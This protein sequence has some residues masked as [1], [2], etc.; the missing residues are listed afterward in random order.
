MIDMTKKQG[1]W[2]TRF[3]KLGDKVF[4]ENDPFNQPTDKNSWARDNY[5]Q[6]EMPPTRSPLTGKYYTS[7]AALRAEYRSHGAEEV[8]TAYENGYDPAE[9]QQRREAD[10]V[11]SIKDQII[12]RYRNGR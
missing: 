7:K 1:T 5:P 3:G 4:G 11:R 8:G 10:L 12:D 2:P 6:D 9:K